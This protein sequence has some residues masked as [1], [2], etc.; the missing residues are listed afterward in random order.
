MISHKENHWVRFRF[1]L[2][3]RLIEKRAYVLS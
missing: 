2:L 1:Q 3:Q